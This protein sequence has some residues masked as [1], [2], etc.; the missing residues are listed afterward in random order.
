[1][2]QKG[3]VPKKLVKEF[4]EKRLEQ[5]WTVVQRRVYQTQNHSVDELKWRAID[6]WCGLE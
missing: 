3:T 2:I 5:N 6:V 4:P 1:M